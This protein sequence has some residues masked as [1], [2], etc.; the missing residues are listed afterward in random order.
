MPNLVAL[1]IR[2]GFAG[3]W[4]LSTIISI[5]THQ[6]STGNYLGPYSIKEACKGSLPV[7]SREEDTEW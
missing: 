4:A 2:I 5:R 7:R 3:F 6:N 1:I